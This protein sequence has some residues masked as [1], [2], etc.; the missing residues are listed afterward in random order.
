M[1]RGEH[2]HTRWTR[3]E[4]VALRLF[5]AASRSRLGR[6]GRLFD[7]HLAE[8]YFLPPKKAFHAVIEDHRDCCCRGVDVLLLC[9]EVVGQV[10]FE[11]G[12]ICPRFEDWVVTAWIIIAHII[13]KFRLAEVEVSPLAT[14]V[15]D[16]PFAGQGLA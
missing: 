4:L 6:H 15:C 2:L 11:K 13:Y 12:P 3:M 10:G 7:W 1:G 9:P 16:R 8:G 14:L 5:G